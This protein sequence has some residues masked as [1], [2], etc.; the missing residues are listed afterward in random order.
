MII[1]IID[2]DDD[3]ELVEPNGYRNQKL[4]TQI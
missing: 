4:K 2:N 1:L 3:V